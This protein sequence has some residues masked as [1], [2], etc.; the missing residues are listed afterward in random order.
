MPSKLPVPALLSALVD[1]EEG[2]VISKAPRNEK[3]NNT[4]KAKT[5]D[6][7]SSWSPGYLMLQTRKLK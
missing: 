6:W 7:L 3:P 5:T 1:H 4:N 2:N